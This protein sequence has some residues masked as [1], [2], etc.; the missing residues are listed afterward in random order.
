MSSSLKCYHM[1]DLEGEHQQLIFAENRSQAIIRSD[2]YQWDGDYIRVR[3]IRQPQYDAYAQL[4]SVP[5]EILLED[6][7]WFECHG[8]DEHGRRCCKVLTIEDEPLVVDDLVYCKEHSNTL[9][10]ASK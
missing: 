6:G 7:W 9:K 3:A 8:D 10:E 5:K 2:A 1:S 4:G